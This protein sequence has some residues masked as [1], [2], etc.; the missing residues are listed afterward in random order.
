MATSF[1]EVRCRKDT[2]PPEGD[3]IEICI[4][5]I[6]STSMGCPEETLSPS[7]TLYPII[8]PAAGARIWM[9]FLGA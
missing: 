6:S 8:M 9:L 1:R 5:I 4:F 2:L 7:A 3:V